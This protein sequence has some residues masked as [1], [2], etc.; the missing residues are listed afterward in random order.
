MTIDKDFKRL[1]RARMEKTGESYTA[2][3]TQI[4]KSDPGPEG[5]GLR[6]RT[7]EPRNLGTPEPGVPFAVLA[8]MS[9]AAVKA[10]TGCTWEGW[11]GALD[12]VKAYAWPHRA[13]AEYV[14]EKYKVRD[15]WTQTV[16]VGYERIKGLR[17]HGQ[18]RGGSYE[19]SKSKTFGVPMGRLYEA[20]AKPKVRAQWL[21]G[22][23]L[24]VRKATPNRSMR[25]TWGDGTS[26]ELWF[27]KKERSKSQVAVQCTRLPSKDVAAQKKQYWEERLSALEAMLT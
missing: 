25:I 12:A 23:E 1:V 3:R 10:K 6:T 22:A 8:G 11:V 2:A 19:A 5:P 15:W 14:H 17:D 18:R 26:V 4:R 27:T 20:F 7:S 9:D 24:A 13:I 16:T 21:N